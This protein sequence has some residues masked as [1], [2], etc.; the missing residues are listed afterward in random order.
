MVNADLSQAAKFDIV[1]VKGKN[2][3]RRKPEKRKK[4]RVKAN[5]NILRR[6]TRNSL[7]VQLIYQ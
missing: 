7:N 6:T 4:R 1:P 3:K 5:Q 2:T